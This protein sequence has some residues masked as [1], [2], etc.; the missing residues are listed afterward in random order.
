MRNL[1]QN[2]MKLTLSQAQCN[3]NAQPCLHFIVLSHWLALEYLFMQVF[4][5]LENSKFQDTSSPKWSR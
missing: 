5:N 4:K 3:N 2:V 1:Q